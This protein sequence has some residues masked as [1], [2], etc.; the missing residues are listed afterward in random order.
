ME[1]GALKSLFNLKT[2][3]QT[4]AAEFRPGQI[5]NGKI[6]KLYP[7]QVAQVQ[8]GN[9]IMVAQLEVPLSANERYWFQVQSGEGKVHLKVISASGEDKGQSGNLTKILAEFSM[10]PTKENLELIRFFIKEQLPV[11]IDLLK[12]ASEWLKTADSLSAGQDAIKM[13][14]TRGIPVTRSSFDALST[15]TKEQS[16]VLLM[17][18]LGKALESVNQTDTGA[19][20]RRLLNEML[21]SNRSLTS[22]TALNHLVSAWL[23]DNGK[24]SQAALD[25]LKRFGAVPSK[26]E[27]SNVLQQMLSKLQSLETAQEDLPA[28][29]RFVK[30]VITLLENG[31]IPAARQLLTGSTNDKTVAVNRI[32]D[33]LRLLVDQTNGKEGD[34]QKGLQ[35]FKGLLSLTNDGR[36]LPLLLRGE[37]DWKQAG[38]KLLE[39]ASRQQSIP[40]TGVQAQL[41]T[42]AIVKTE[43]TLVPGENGTSLLTD[44]RIKSF[45]SALGLSYE[46]QL[47]EAMKAGESGRLQV[48]DTLKSL[49][50]RLLN[51][52]PPPV[53][54]EAAEPLLNKLTGF[55][56]LSQEAGPIQQLVV[57]VPFILGGNARDLTMQWSGKRT[58]DG[59]IDADY[60]RV[61]FYL[62][63][64]NLD[65][66]IV[67]MQVQNR[68]MSLQIF[69][70]HP[71]L[72]KMA[73]QMTPILKKKLSELDYK[74]SSVHFHTPGESKAVWNQR[75]LSELY[76][77][78]EYSGVDIKI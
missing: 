69:N 48:P 62:K 60:C 33:S 16:L 56:L 30:S 38:V 54:R 4:K 73:E 10:Q 11:N 6:V 9:Q 57:Q 12:Q 49:L 74:L 37:A 76:G 61:L 75:S 8:I 23:K 53:V 7:D 50:L 45:L 68:V 24:E 71:F 21:P 5:I 27:E 36:T 18:Q 34:L 55:Q 52:N 78:K 42:E 59:K 31:E 51:E 44:S 46:Q 22:E 32:L 63:L 2:T 35:A 41:L 47:S 26:N 20:L 19:S 66:T 17:E 70:D 64:Q 29:L 13:M 77:Q 3:Q 28:G 39:A 67:D 40:L 72:K 43:P 14:L 15:I 1:T 58:E 65:D 25:L